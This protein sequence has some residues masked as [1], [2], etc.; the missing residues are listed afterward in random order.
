MNR[1]I[2]VDNKLLFSGG[3]RSST[4]VE[5]GWID[6]INNTVIYPECYSDVETI[7]VRDITYSYSDQSVYVSWYSLR[8][9]N[10]LD[11]EYRTQLDNGIKSAIRKLAEYHLDKFDTVNNTTFS[12]ET[13]RRISKQCTDH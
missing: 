2:P 11:K 4:A 9:Q 8:E 5:F 10:L 1:M 7:N 6:L 3:K 13:F 12:V